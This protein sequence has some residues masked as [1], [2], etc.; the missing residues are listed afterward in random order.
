MINLKYHL[1]S[2]VITVFC[3]IFSIGR[4]IALVGILTTSQVQQFS[5][6]FQSPVLITMILL[7]FLILSILSSLLSSLL[8]CFSPVTRFFLSCSSLV[9]ESCL[10]FS[11]FFHHDLVRSLLSD[12]TTSSSVLSIFSPYINLIFYSILLLLLAINPNNLF[13]SIFINLIKFFIV[14]LPSVHYYAN[15]ININ[16]AESH[17]FICFVASIIISF[18]YSKL[19]LKH[20]KPGI[21][22]KILR[23]IFIEEPTGHVP[24]QIQKGEIFGISEL[25]SEN[26]EEN[27]QNQVPEIVENFEQKLEVQN[28]VAEIVENFEGN[29]QFEVPEIVEN[30]E[31]KLEVQ[32]EVV[33]NFE[34][35]LQ[36][37][38]PEIV[39]N[40]EQ[41][42]EVQNEVAEIVENF[43]QK[44][45]VQNEVVENFEENL[46]NQ[47][48]EIVENFEQ[49]IEVQNEVAEI[50][51]NFEQKLEVQ[52]EVAEIVENFEQKL[53]VQNE[54]AEIVE[55]FEGNLQFEVPE[56]VE[57]FEQKLEVQNEVAEI[58]ENFEQKLE[59][60]NEVVENVEEN[61]QN[62][63]PEIV[64]NFEQNEVAEVAENFEENLQLE[65]P[66]IVENFEQKLEVQNEVAEIVENFEQKLEVQN[67]VA[68]IVENFEENL[69]LEVPEIVENFEENLQLE[70]PEI[71]ENFEQKLE[72]QN[73]VAEIVEN[74]EQKLEVQNEVAEIVENFEGN[75]QFEVPEIV[76]N[77]E[78]KLEVQN[79]VAEIVE[80]FE[81]N[82]QF[83]VPE[84]VENFEQK[85]EVQ[86][87]VAEIVENFEEKLHSEVSDADEIFNDTVDIQ[88]EGSQNF[89]ESF[90]DFFPSDP[91]LSPPSFSTTSLSPQ[92]LPLSTPPRPSLHQTS[93]KPSP[94]LL[95]SPT[96][97]I[98]LRGVF[99]KRPTE[100]PSSLLFPP[101]RQW[102][103]HNY[104]LTVR[105]DTVS[106]LHGE[107]R[108]NTLNNKISLNSSSFVRLCI[109][110]DIT[111]LD[112]KNASCCV[113]LM[114]TRGEYLY[115]TFSSTHKA[116]TF[117]DIVNR[118]I[119]DVFDVD[120]S[121][122][123]VPQFINPKT[124]LTTSTQAHVHLSGQ[125]VTLDQTLFSER[126]RW[127]SKVFQISTI[128][129]VT[130]VCIGDSPS[131]FDTIIALN[132]SVVCCPCSS[133][134]PNTVLSRDHVSK[135]VK[136]S[137]PSRSTFRYLIFRSSLE[138]KN[139]VSTV[140]I[141]IKGE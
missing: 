83:E 102:T 81:G 24:R 92:Q 31:Q 98:L 120:N 27:L 121:P 99:Q 59:V 113:R 64:E 96:S 77:F 128:G 85:L 46:Q 29:L 105:G 127:A 140:E 114:I 39:E 137:D 15:L 56:I 74:F 112:G 58:V 132:E 33:E 14:L 53:E 41:K 35:N 28:E 51:E 36:N 129:Q 93:F 69:Q 62:Q 86:N 116:S 6:F 42:I 73:E 1:I 117:V 2:F 79:E 5:P 37:Q 23:Q 100:R 91:S 106:L 19:K 45:E 111:K 90:E 136:I 11:L 131:Y 126:Y 55:N 115:F 109:H 43:E 68:E 44:L 82:L 88:L 70:V 78:Q 22:V 65:V 47:V 101:V 32:N 12:L 135:A 87:E 122:F 123:S 8:S 4:E 141:F 17:F 66:E 16:S 110:S 94:K 25:F 3:T 52:N 139:F 49:K 95:T 103:T 118:A 10:R 104:Y 7:N 138:A 34:E 97:K 50:V 125:F 89:G 61:L 107:K 26:F 75:L 124:L 76:E 133:H 119:C 63:V 20:R 80:N 40:F 18:F 54:V 72:V 13:T 30:F 38:V 21:K 134:E 67:E 84:I 71:V 9:L 48:P 60:Q 57:N 108:T 130:S